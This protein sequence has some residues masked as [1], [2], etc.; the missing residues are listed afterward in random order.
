[1]NIKNLFQL[2]QQFERLATS[3]PKYSIWWKNPDHNKWEVYQSGLAK[4]KAETL[5]KKITLVL[6]PRWFDHNVPTRVLLDGDII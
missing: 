5:A 4:S 6:S 2:S 3:K 1:M